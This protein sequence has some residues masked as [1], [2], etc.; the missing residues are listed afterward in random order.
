LAG[1][2]VGGAVIGLLAAILLVCVSVVSRYTIK[3]KDDVTR[4]EAVRGFPTFVRRYVNPDPWEVSVSVAKWELVWMIAF[5][6]AALCWVGLV[7]VLS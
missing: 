6:L 3:L 1:V 4:R 5:A 2:A 7:E